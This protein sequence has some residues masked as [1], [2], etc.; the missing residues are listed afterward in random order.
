MELEITSALP[1]LIGRLQIPDADVI[2]RALQALIIAEE[3]GYPSLGRSNIGGLHSRPDFL[4]RRDTAVFSIDEY[5]GV[6]R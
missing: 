1:T 3:A 4:S 2:N 6:V 5:K